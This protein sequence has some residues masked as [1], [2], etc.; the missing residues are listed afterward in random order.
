MLQENRMRRIFSLTALA[1]TIAAILLPAASLAQSRPWGEGYIPNLPVITQDGKTLRFY[2][3]LVKGKIVIISFIYTSCTD[4]CPVTTAR[5]AQLE[6]RLGDRVGRD[7]FLVSMTVDPQTDTPQRLKEYAEA[8]GAGPGWSFV[9]GSADNIRAINFKFG[10]RSKVLSE[11][12]NEIVLGNDATGEWQR[13][14]IFGD[15]DRLVMTVKSLDPKWRDQVRTPAYSPA[16][17]TGL[18]VSQQPG[19]AL[20]KKICAPC[21]TI[22]VGDRVGPDLRGVTARRERSW[23]TAFIQ[24]PARLRAQRDPAALALAETYPVV[25]MPALGVGQNDASDLI[26]Y[27]D[28]EEVR[29]AGARGASEEEQKSS[30]RHHHH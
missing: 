14:S 17:N 19:Q 29:L 22:G 6:E 20:F 3:D 4:I 25:R 15:I 11:H 27:L 2:D 16:S 23:L 9:T 18:A 8:F 26:A 13:D 1:A 21:H 12:R 30:N 28:A 10:E 5:L 24:N 7:V